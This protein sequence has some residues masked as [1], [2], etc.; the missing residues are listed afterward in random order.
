MAS[1]EF[2]ALLATEMLPVTLTALDGLKVTARV[3]VFPGPKISPVGTPVALKPAPFTV[4]L[5]IVTFEFPALV[6]V[7]FWLLLLDTLTFPKIKA[8]ELELRIIVAALTVSVAGLLV[9]LPTLLVAVTENWALLSAV[10]S[11][12]VV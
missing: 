7:T 2:E 11:A 12:G 6:K 8:A 10:V 5:E 1:G 3:V 9:A 4:T